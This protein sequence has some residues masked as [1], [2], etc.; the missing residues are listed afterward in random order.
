MNP[1]PIPLKIVPNMNGY[2]KDWL[3]GGAPIK[4]NACEN[5]HNPKMANGDP[6]KKKKAATAFAPTFVAEEFTFIFCGMPDCLVRDRKSS[7]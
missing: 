7:N 2:M 6:N 5:A 1:K 3:P 4:R